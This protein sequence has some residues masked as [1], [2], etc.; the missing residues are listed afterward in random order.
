MVNFTAGGFYLAFLFPLVGFAGR[1]PS[2]TVA[3]R[4]L[5]LRQGGPCA[6]GGRRGVGD[7]SSSSTSPGRGTSTPT[8]A[9]LDWS[10]GLAVL[11]LA[12]V[13]TVIYASVRRRIT[14]SDVYDEDD[15]S[16]LADLQVGR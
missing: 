5:Q 9:L 2:R 15:E 14:T 1:P 10:V 8:S 13:G 11:A 4:A 7:A 16:D 12:V 3:A 6:V